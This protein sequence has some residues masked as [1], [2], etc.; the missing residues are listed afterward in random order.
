MEALARWLADTETSQYE[1]ARA[2][3]VSQPT[4]SDWLR[5]EKLPTAENLRLIVKRTGLSADKLLG[6]SK[7]VH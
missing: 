6:I 5:G 3:G 2:I 7:E 1:F 4:I